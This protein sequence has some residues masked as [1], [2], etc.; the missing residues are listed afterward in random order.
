MLNILSELRS[1]VIYSALLGGDD[2]P[3]KYLRSCLDCI[4]SLIESE[5]IILE[6]RKLV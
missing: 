2:Y 4:S 1:K 5:T 6:Q 3:S